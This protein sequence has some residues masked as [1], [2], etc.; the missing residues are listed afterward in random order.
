MAV[1]GGMETMMNAEEAEG[2]R[3]RAVDAARMR[4]SSTVQAYLKL[5]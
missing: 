1:D 2:A 5:C 3:M 4:G